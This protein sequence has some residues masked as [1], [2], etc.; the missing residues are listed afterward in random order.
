M[1]SA[2]FKFGIFFLALILMGACG[3]KGPLYLPV[4]E[5]KIYSPTAQKTSGNYNNSADSAPKQ[6]L[7]K[8]E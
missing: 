2:I 3:Q 7:N 6:F 1:Q 4:D 5:S 8:K